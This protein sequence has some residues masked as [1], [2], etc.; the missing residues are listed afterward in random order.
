MKKI[1]IYK[2]RFE[3]MVSVAKE[4]R[5]WN[6]GWKISKGKKKRWADLLNC[7]EELDGCNLIEEALQLVHWGYLPQD[8][9]S[10]KER[11]LIS[12]IAYELKSR[13]EA[14][15]VWFKDERVN[16]IFLCV[17]DTMDPFEDLYQSSIVHHESMARNT[18]WEV[19][20]KH[21]D[22]ADAQKEAFLYKE[23]VRKLIPEA[24]TWTKA[25]WMDD[26]HIFAAVKETYGIDCEKVDPNTDP[27]WYYAG[28]RYDRIAYF[29]LL[30][31]RGA[32]DASNYALIQMPIFTTELMCVLCDGHEKEYMIEAYLRAYSWAQAGVIKNLRYASH[33]FGY[34]DIKNSFLHSFILNSC[35]WSENQQLKDAVFDVEMQV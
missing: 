35:L 18:V 8:G 3:K 30:M 21:P 28:I 13:G 31:Q 2:D 6:E 12:L 10:K 20:T 33:K 19:L 11:E 5:F 27:S 23:F 14:S 26:Q 34:S 17:I 22:Y 1:D 4:T 32:R 7:W 24:V 29:Y 16:R 15:E 9:Y 25:R